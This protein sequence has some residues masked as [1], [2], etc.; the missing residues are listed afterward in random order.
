MAKVCEITCIN[1]DNN[2]TTVYNGQYTNTVNSD[3]REGRWQAIEGGGELMKKGGEIY[4]FILYVVVTGRK[5]T[6]FRGRLFEKMVTQR[7]F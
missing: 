6:L 1:E 5:R 2:P 7:C 4:R 3:N